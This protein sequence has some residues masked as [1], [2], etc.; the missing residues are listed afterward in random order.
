METSL[1]FIIAKKKKY[2]LFEIKVRYNVKKYRLTI[3]SIVKESNTY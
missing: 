1:I 2:R 3:H